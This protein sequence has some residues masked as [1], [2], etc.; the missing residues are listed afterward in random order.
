MDRAYSE[1]TGATD[2]S[3]IAAIITVQATR[4]AGSVRPM[5]PVMGPPCWD[6]V[7]IATQAIAAVMRRTAAC[8]V[9]RHVSTADK[10][11]WVHQ[12]TD[13]DELPV[14]PAA[15]T[16]Y[17]ELMVSPPRGERWPGSGPRSAPT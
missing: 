5:V 17:A 11:A 8:G 15:S 6:H 10:A 1:A 12:P 14:A 16:T 2:G 13:G 9:R 3:I 7:M 4:N